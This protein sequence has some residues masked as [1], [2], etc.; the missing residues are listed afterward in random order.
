MHKDNEK[1]EELYRR[2][3]ALKGDGL[4]YAQLARLLS[5]T[6]RKT[7]AEEQALIAMGLGCMDK[8]NPIWKDLDI[9]PD[10]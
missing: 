1:A 10:E 2:A 4:F 3:V 9:N 8:T 7:E 5:D 6:G